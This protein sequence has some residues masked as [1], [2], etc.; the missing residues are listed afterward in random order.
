MSDVAAIY[1][2]HGL[3][4]NFH[5]HFALLFYCCNQRSVFA[6]G[7]RLSNM[8]ML[9]YGFELDSRRQSTDQKK[10]TFNVD[11]ITSIINYYESLN[12]AAE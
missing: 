6:H 7:I 11:Q 3:L 5:V 8:T 4:Q 1:I 12:S 9:K 2:T 10:A